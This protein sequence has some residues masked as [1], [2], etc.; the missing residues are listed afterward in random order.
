MVVKQVRDTKGDLLVD[1]LLY[2]FGGSVWA[3]R[4]VLNFL[5]NTLSIGQSPSV[6]TAEFKGAACAGHPQEEP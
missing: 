1:K 3:R 2:L 6:K 4:V 5:L